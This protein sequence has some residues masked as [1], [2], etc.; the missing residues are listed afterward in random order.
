MYLVGLGLSGIGLSACDLEKSNPDFRPCTLTEA[1]C[2]SKEV[3]NGIDDDQ[4]INQYGTDPKTDQAI[5]Y[6][7]AVETFLKQGLEECD[8]FEATVSKL[9][10][11]VPV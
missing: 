2:I 7:E 4:E 9:E 3:C 6:I 10:S 1:G 5:D 11:L 8:D